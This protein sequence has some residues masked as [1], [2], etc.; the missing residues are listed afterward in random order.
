MSFSRSCCLKPYS[1]CLWTL[2]RWGTCNLPL[3]PHPLVVHFPYVQSESILNPN[4]NIFKLKRIH[5]KIV[6]PFSV[7]WDIGKVCLS[8]KRF[9][10]Y[11]K[12]GIRTLVCIFQ[13]AQTKLF[14]PFFTEKVWK[15]LW[16]VFGPAMALLI[17]PCLSGAGLHRAGHSTAGRVSQQQTREG[18]LSR[19]TWRGPRI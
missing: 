7:T 5:F 1:T 11:W 3:L 8:Y 13:A 10:R 2:Q 16:S 15:C 17:W 9:L 18:E 12:V 4:L 6:K 14:H 19:V